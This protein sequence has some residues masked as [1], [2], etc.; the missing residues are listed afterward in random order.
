MRFLH[1]VILNTV[2]VIAD[3]IGRAINDH[4]S[5]KRELV[6]RAMDEKEAKKA[7]KKVKTKK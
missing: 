6:I 4:I 7:N 3:H 1:Y 5:F 2:P